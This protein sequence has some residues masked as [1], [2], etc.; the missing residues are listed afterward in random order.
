MDHDSWPSFVGSRS[1]H[2]RSSSC[3]GS[4]LA[5]LP[6]QLAVQRRNRP[7]PRPSSGGGES[8]TRRSFRY[9]RLLGH[10]FVASWAAIPWCCLRPSTQ[11]I[12][13]QHKGF[14]R[15]R[16]RKMLQTS[17]NANATAKDWEWG[18]ER[19]REKQKRQGKNRDWIVKN[20]LSQVWR[21][22]ERRP[23]GSS[24]RAGGSCV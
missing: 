21:P 17:K 11:L 13:Q 6:V 8:S 4:M 22:P 3:P 15:H 9:R 19:E 20:R 5:Q 12:L 18:R 14:I 23:C 10:V 2:W 1:I 7:S 16:C 24:K